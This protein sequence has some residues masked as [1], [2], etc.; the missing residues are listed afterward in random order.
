MEIVLQRIIAG[1]T[2]GSVYALIAFG[3][4]VIFSASRVVNFA[5]GQ[6]LMV[7]AMVGALLHATLRLPILL[8]FLVVMAVCGLLGLGIERV[9]TIPSRRSGSPYTWIVATIAAAV[10]IENVAALLFGRDPKRMP[11]LWG[12]PP[13]RLGEITV[14]RR[15][16]LVIAVAL[17]LMLVL[18]VFIR[19]TFT[20]KALRAAAHDPAV[21]R[22]MG[23]DVARL[24]MFAYVLAGVVAGI[25]GVLV[26]PITFASVSMALPLGLK[27][28][29]AVVIGGMGS[30]RGALAG[31]ILLGIFEAQIRAGLPKGFG[32][33]ALFA[34]LILFLLAL[35][36]GLL[37]RKTAEIRT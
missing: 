4:S 21:A 17:A 18:D 23:V 36:R 8:T 10:V 32:T 7:G 33:A 27:G 35:P 24:T 31:G 13:F 15:T 30:T 34:V 6:V 3:F 20:G 16:I 25:G 5:Q 22:L 29:I 28:F 14:E 11:P 2:A 9:V 26:A 37:G 19:R 12:G 1:L